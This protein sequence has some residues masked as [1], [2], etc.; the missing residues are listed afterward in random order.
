[1]GNPTGLWPAFTFH[2][3]DKMTQWLQAIGFTPLR[4]IRSDGDSN[5]VVHAELLNTRSSVSC[6][7]NILR[8]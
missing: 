1:M 4:I 8:T 2:D 7:G 3:A 5:A 6:T